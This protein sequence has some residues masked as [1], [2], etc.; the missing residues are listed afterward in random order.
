M[1]W[2]VSFWAPVVPKWGAVWFC[3]SESK[4]ACNLFHDIS[5]N[6]IFLP[7]RQRLSALFPSASSALRVTSLWLTYQLKLTGQQPIRTPSYQWFPLRILF[8]SKCTSCEKLLIFS[9]HFYFPCWENRVGGVKRET[10]RQRLNELPFACCLLLRC[11]ELTTWLCSGARGSIRVFH[12]P[13]WDPLPE[14]SLL[15]PLSAF[16]A[17]SWSLHPALVLNPDRTQAI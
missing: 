16:A 5:L 15:P 17:G 7:Q 11:P 12:M 4:F 6:Y 3:C 14:P 10:K 8:Y 1:S 13:S 2:K 9:V